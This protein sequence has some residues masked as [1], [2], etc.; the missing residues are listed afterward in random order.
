ML[1]QQGLTSSEA[2]RVANFLKEMVKAIDITTDNFAIV[3]SV[4][5]RD[6]KEL[7]LDTNIKVDGWKDLILAKAR[8]Y[9]LSAWLN[10]AIKLKDSKIMAE[11]NK[12][13]DISQVP[14]VSDELEKFP[15]SPV[16]QSTT[17][18]EFLRT[19]SIKEYAEY[20]KQQAIAAHVGTF[21]HNF[22]DIR[23]QLNNFQPTQFKNIS[24][25]ETVTVSN[26]LLYSKDELL[27]GAEELFKE[28][29]EA[30]KI[31][32]S[33][34][35]RHKE[36]VAQKEREYQIALDKYNTDVA[37][38]TRANN[39]VN[40]KYQSAFEIEKTDELKVLSAL[41]IEI[42]HDLQPILDEVLEKLNK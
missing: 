17:L 6:G 42:P 39:A 12:Y 37:V 35:A 21:I 14:N 27:N 40:Q 29:R 4:A 25:T 9:S 7:P 3:T 11:R 15:P 41:R 19:L 28:H 5:Q 31:L 1:G 13:F 10:E 32:N 2:S 33:F 30:E 36:W 26:T 24:N 23:A 20:L 34:L 16:R 38:I 8:Y 18:P 22:D